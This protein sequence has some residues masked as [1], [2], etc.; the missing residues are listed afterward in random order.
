MSEFNELSAERPINSASLESIELRVKFDSGVAT[1]SKVLFGNGR[2]QVKVQ[3]LVSGFDENGQ[4]I[5]VPADVLNTVELIHY[6]TG[7]TLRDGWT[8]S[9]E[10][11][12]YT[13][14]APVSADLMDASDDESHYHAH[15]H[16]RTFWVSSAGVGTTQIAARVLLNGTVIQS[17]GT[18]LIDR[19][20]SSITLDAQLP[21]SYSLEQF[22]L[23]SVRRGNEEPGN[24]ISNYYLGLNHQGQQIKLVD[25]VA[26]RGTGNL[27]F[28]HGNWLGAPATNYLI[29]ILVGP[30]QTDV[31]VKLP[32]NDNNFLDTVFSGPASV[33]SE[34]SKE[35]PVRVGDRHGELTIVQ[36]ISEYAYSYAKYT[37]DEV[38]HFS[39]IDQYGSEH[40]LAIRTN[41]TESLFILERG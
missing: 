31:T 22:H 7:K 21:I 34:M 28:A 3:V 19:Q 10:Q 24:R 36:A 27:V 8:A 30:D 20:D 18:G 16:V 38:F 23:K 32:V 1:R 5:S 13:L 37:V 35:Y 15:P 25:W 17:N 11:G 12:R 9:A 41:A 29:G 4:H 14:E 2:M 40:K 26:P 6:N 39:A 33:S